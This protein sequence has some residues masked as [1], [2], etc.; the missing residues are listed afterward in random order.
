V[1]LDLVDNHQA[2]CSRAMG[3]ALLPDLGLADRQEAVR[4]ARRA[5]ELTRWKEP[6]CLHALATAHCSVANAQAQSGQF[7][8]AVDN[9]YKSLEADELGEDALFN[10]AILRMTCPDPSI[11]DPD[12]AVRLAE[13]GCK[14]LGQ[15][16][17]HRLAILSEAYVAA[18]RLDMAVATAEKAVQIA[19][20]A[21]DSS[22]VDEI[23][24]WLEERRE[25]PTIRPNGV[26]GEAENGP[27]SDAPAPS[28]DD[29]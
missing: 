3:L 15:P 13:R 27:T 8:S 18:G 19:Q 9:Y 6:E 16:T 26:G 5:C 10:L 4:L 12:E 14:A 2:L 11:R 24:R 29:E 21:G 22:T 20:A 28:H 23:R 25:R 1:E 17:P 7:V